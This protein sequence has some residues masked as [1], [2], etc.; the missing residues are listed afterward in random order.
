M[1]PEEAWSGFKP[2]LAYFKVFGSIA[3]V[4]IPDCK[5]VKLDDKSKK[6]VF[7]GVSEE[8]KAYRLYD[9]VSNKIIVSR[10]VVFDEE[11]SWDWEKSHKESVLINLDWGEKYESG[12]GLS[13]EETMNFAMFA[14]ND[15]IFFEAAQKNEKWRL[16]MDAEI[17]AIEKNDTWEM[18][19]LPHGAKKV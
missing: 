8:S 18:T 17:E 19:D 11:A 12:E 14:E 10:D 9:P 1:C 15:P 16:T 6:C 3:Y 13:E 5:R 2:S 4:H 7:L